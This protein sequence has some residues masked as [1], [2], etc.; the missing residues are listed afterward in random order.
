MLKIIKHS[1]K[2]TQFSYKN[3][4]MRTDLLGNFQPVNITI[5]AESIRMLLSYHIMFYKT[6]YGN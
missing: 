4:V 1:I 5:A 6:A 3:I 2:E